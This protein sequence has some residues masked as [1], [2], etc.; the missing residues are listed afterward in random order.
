MESPDL[1]FEDFGMAKLKR[2]RAVVP[3]D[4]NFAKV[5]KTG[6][7]RV[8]FTPEGD[9]RGLHLRRKSAIGPGAWGYRH[10]ECECRCHRLFH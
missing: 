6:D 5:I 8:F 2:G 3:L 7:Y 1:W 9:C 10:Y 4:A